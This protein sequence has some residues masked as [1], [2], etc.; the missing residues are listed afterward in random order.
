MPN[1]MDNGITVLTK[2]PKGKVPWPQSFIP[3]L[4][5]NST[6]KK[7]D[8]LVGELNEAKKELAPIKFKVE[9]LKSKDAN[10]KKQ[11][12]KLETKVRIADQ[13]VTAERE[14]LALCNIYS[15]EE[16]NNRKDLNLRQAF[17]K[18]FN[19]RAPDLPPAD[20]DRKTK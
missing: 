17:E 14:R 8:D 3:A 11:L 1:L 18:D 13:N 12:E 20:L 10:V 9:V 2:D 16:K 4:T 7:L 5:N 15:S 6:A 19:K